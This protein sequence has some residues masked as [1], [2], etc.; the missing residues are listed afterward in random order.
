M[1]LVLKAE[2]LRVV[3]NSYNR[4]VF[5]VRDV[6]FG[7]RSGKVTALVG[8]SGC[9]KSVTALTLGGL[10][11]HSR[12]VEISGRL[13]I[14]GIEIAAAE[15]KG[16]RKIRGSKIAYVFQDPST[17]LNPVMRIGSQMLEATGN[18][19]DAERLFEQVRL[20]D[21]KAVM[22]A[23]P[24]ELSGGMQQRV[25]LA[26]ALA[27]APRIL[28]ADEPTTALDVT[29]QAQIIELLD[30]LRRENGMSVLLITHN[31]GLVADI[32]DDVMVMYAGRLVESGEVA[33]VLKEPRH[34]YSR[35]LLDAVPRLDPRQRP[36]VAIAG[37]VP[38]LSEEPRGCAF[39]PRCR[40]N[41][42]RCFLSDPEWAGTDEHAWRCFN[43]LD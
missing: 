17:A 26:M 24:H 40:R 10:L 37:N 5:A 12:G 16:W 30:E 39:A 27:A 21:V 15:R 43:P 28:I 14:D 11:P 3:F 35:G 9:G 13:S 18:R 2:N 23:Y 4:Q 29:V 7:M 25:M 31:L 38:D 19:F 8:E 32:A 41:I 36:A 1:N 6:S 33:A 20:A 22:S 34:P 42:E